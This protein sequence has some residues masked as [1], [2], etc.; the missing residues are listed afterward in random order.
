MLGKK[1]QTLLKREPD[2]LGWREK[3]SETQRRWQVSGGHT[4]VGSANWTQWVIVKKEEKVK[5]G[6][7]MGEIQGELERGDRS[8]Y[9]QNT[10]YAYV[11]ISTIN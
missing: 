9:D 3:A 6:G 1:H 11:K 7:G 2:K 5:M 8:G 4:C 10:L